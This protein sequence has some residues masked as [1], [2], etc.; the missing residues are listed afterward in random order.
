MNVQAFSAIAT[1]FRSR[2]LHPLQFPGAKKTAP[3][4]STPQRPKGSAAP[5]AAGRKAPQ[6]AMDRKVDQARQDLARVGEDHKSDMDAWH[7]EHSGAATDLLHTFNARMTDIQAQ[8][9]P[10]TSGGW[11]AYNDTFGPHAKPS[12]PAAP[13]PA[14]PVHNDQQFN[15]KNYGLAATAA[16][17]P[18]RVY[19]APEPQAHTDHP[20][21]PPQP[22]AG[23]IGRGVQRGLFS[24][25]DAGPKVKAVRQPVTKPVQPGPGPGQM[26]FDDLPAAPRAK[27]SAASSTPPGPP[28]TGVK[29]ASSPKPPAKKAAPK[30]TTS[31]TGR[32]T[33]SSVE[34]KP[35][36]KMGAPAPVKN[37]SQFPSD[38]EWHSM[39]N[40]T[41]NERKK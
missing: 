29:M 36:P 18:Q 2:Y 41:V 20:L 31:R 16:P 12:T 9:K 1:H 13:T 33:S 6:R 4:R 14:A 7:A 27:K 34:Y 30:Q 25:K 26:S 22:S 39:L 38:D 19:H 28:P 17:R 8:K 24:P 5:A 15:Q 40:E 32:L 35:A 10:S 3:A 11:A 37:P 21:A 23:G